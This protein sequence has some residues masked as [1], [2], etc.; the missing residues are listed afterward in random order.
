MGT[1]DRLAG[2]YG[3]LERLAF[4][5]D[6]ERARFCWLERL[7]GCRSILILGEGDGRCLECLVRVAPVAH[8][9]CVDASAAMLTRAARR[10]A[11]TEAESRVRFEQADAF[12]VPLAPG[13]YDAVLTFFFL[14][15]FPT[16]RVEELIGRIGPSMAPDALWLF[17]DFVVPAQGVRR[18]R[19]RIWLAVLYGFFRW[20]TK[21]AARALPDSE[22]ALRAAGWVVE[23]QGE[24]NRRFVRSAVYA[25]SK[26]LDVGHPG[27]V[28]QAVGPVANRSSSL[29]S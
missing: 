18:L 9:H 14:D 25:R 28:A 10:I 20:Q 11:G 21:L 17:A 19:A 15:C 24:F 26:S 16:G 12:S 8:I 22:G 2:I 27:G 29:G 23:A 5:R 7:N 1:F 6:L 3:G 13:A 4:G